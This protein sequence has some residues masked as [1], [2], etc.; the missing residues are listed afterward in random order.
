MSDTGR[1]LFKMYT[2]AGADVL[3]HRLQH[4]FVPVRTPDDTALHN[5]ALKEVLLMIRGD[6]RKFL[7]GMVDFILYKPVDREKRFLF[8]IAH[9]ILQ[10][11]QR[12]G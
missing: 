2:K 10:I 5:A 12:N 7:K 11:S 9:L 6:E 4:I 3:A 8:R 1:S